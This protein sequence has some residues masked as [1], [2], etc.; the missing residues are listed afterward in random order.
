MEMTGRQSLEPI[1]QHCGQVQHTLLDFFEADLFLKFDRTLEAIEE[2]EVLSREIIL[3]GGRHKI[4]SA[5]VT[6]VLIGFAARPCGND[7]LPEVRR[8]IEKS[9][10]LRPAK[11]LVT[12]RSVGMDTQILHIR[13]EHSHM[14]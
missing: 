10:A 11:P 1:T 3:R 6:P 9:N 14:D 8:D 2:R 13:L 7:V 12:A 5:I 4:E